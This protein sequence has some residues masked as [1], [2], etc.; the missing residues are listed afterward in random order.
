MKDWRVEVF[1]DGKWMTLQPHSFT[2]KVDAEG[3]KLGM[4][5]ALIPTPWRAWRAGVM[6]AVDNG[7]IEA[8]E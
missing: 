3:V 1:R 5:G 4:D 6:V 2:L 8:V 7:D